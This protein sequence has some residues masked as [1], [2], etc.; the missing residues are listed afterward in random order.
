[1]D[2]IKLKEIM[3][4]QYLQ[5]DY[6]QMYNIFNNII[7]PMLQKENQK[8]FKQKKEIYYDDSTGQLEEKIS[9]IEIKI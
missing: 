1:M 4:E 6:R 5:H 9:Y 7:L 8:L 3:T 2:I